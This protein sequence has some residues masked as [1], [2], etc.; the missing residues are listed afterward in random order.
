MNGGTIYD[1]YMIW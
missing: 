1:F